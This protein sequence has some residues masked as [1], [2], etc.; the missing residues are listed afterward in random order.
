MHSLR[1]LGIGCAVAG[2]V[3]AT[4]ALAS[5]APSSD[6]PTPVV[7]SDM[8]AAPFNL[9][10]DAH[11]VLIADGMG[12]VGAL[13][14]D[15]SISTVVPDVPGASGVAVRGAWLAY[16]STVTDEATFTNTASGVNIRTPNG[17]TIYADTLAYEEQN[18][19]D[20]VNT[21]GAEPDSCLADIIG[22]EYTGML[23]SHAYTVAAFRGGWVV[24]D[25]GANDILAVDDRGNISTVAVLPPQPYTVT[26]DAAEELGLPDCAIGA[27]YNFEPVPT[28][29][30]V[31]PDGMLYVTTLPGGPES[32][33]LGA[34]GSVWRVNPSTHAVQQV[35]TGFL[36]ATNLALGKNGEI[37][38]AELFAG[39][40]ALVKNGATSTF[41]SLPGVVAVQTSANGTVWA[42]TM[43]NDDPS[44]PGTIVSI[45]N[46]KVHIEGKVH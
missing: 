40:I 22:G 35:A 29:V 44:L 6:P 9:T 37:Y 1:T 7:Q 27:T 20:Q 34:R 25:A 45:T 24:A 46:G 39:R 13:Q 32:P 17:K 43:A 41:A 2:L 19:P 38:V 4:P 8:A 23:D 12:Q 3:I 11:R 10:I 18:N 36:G 5:A 33:E 30:E 21:Y 16:T 14:P 42:G 31:G 26:A 15:G 28:D